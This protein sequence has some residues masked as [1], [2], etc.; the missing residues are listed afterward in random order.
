MS[1]LKTLVTLVLVILSVNLLY[2]QRQTNPGFYHIAMGRYHVVALSDGTV[3]IPVAQL[4]PVK[5]R[6]HLQRLLSEH[7]LTDTVEISVN[8]YLIIDSP[9]IVLVDAGAGTLFQPHAG[10]LQESLASAGYQPADITDVLITHVHV[11]HSGGLIRENKMMFPNAMV[12]VNKKELDFWKENRQPRPGEPNGVTINRPAFLALEPY[13]LNG[14]IKP[15]VGNSEIFPGMN[16]IEKTGHTAGHTIFQLRDTP[17]NIIFLGDLVHLEQVQLP[18][19]SLPD[20]F[21]FDQVDGARQRLSSYGQFA[22]ENY[23]IAAAHISFPGFGRIAA[24]SGNYAWVPLPYSM[25]G[26]LY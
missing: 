5:N 6:I 4:L 26:V 25:Q 19:P 17:L 12:H 9:R 2:A 7:Y 1:Y 8:A 21:D 16:S 20:A 3:P 18:A 13:E 24:K 10:R 23:I 11:D 22:S 15:F 14:R